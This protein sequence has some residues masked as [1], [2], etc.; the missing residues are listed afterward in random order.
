MHANS[1]A[2]E[3]SINVSAEQINLTPIALEELRL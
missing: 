3:R 2:D 1:V